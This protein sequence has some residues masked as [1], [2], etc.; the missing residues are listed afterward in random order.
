MNKTDKMRHYIRAIARFGFSFGILVHINPFIT[1]EHRSSEGF[2]RANDL[3]DFNRR[4]YVCR[5]KAGTSGFRVCVIDLR[6][7][8][9]NVENI[10]FNRF[11]LLNSD[12][13]NRLFEQR[14]FDGHIGN[15]R[16]TNQVT[17]LLSGGLNLSDGDG[18]SCGT[19]TLRKRGVRQGEALVTSRGVGRTGLLLDL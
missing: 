7:G 5:N 6:A 15:V 18:L 16:Y 1:I 14:V 9:K 11:R 3:T 17:P 12:K 19:H 10:S 4:H 8:E 2:K 13:T